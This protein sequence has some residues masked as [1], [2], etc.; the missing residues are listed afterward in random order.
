MKG[1]SKPYR[2]FKNIANEFIKN[3]VVFSLFAIILVTAFFI[4]QFHLL[5]NWDFITRIDNAN[6]LFYS[7]K[8]FD[9]PRAILE[10]FIIGI[11]SYVF[12]GY[13]AYA[14]I[15]LFSI[16][17]A[18]SIYEV[19]KAL[20]LNHFLLYLFVLSPFLIY[21]GI[22]N[23]SELPVI[24]FLL[25]TFAYSLKRKAIAG[26]FLS[27]AILSKYYAIFFIPILFVGIRKKEKN[28]KYIV[29][30]LA[31]MIISLIPYFL[32]EKI[33]FGN[34]ATSILLSYYS[35]LG[36][37]ININAILLGLIEIIFPLSL[38]IIYHKE[39]EKT[40]K[41]KRA[42]SIGIIAL[43][44]IALLTFIDTTKLASGTN[45]MRFAL[46]MSVFS[47]IFAFYVLPKKYQRTFAY[48]SFTLS[49]IIAIILIQELNQAMP[50][51][52]IQR[53]INAYALVFGNKSCIVESPIW[54]YLANKNIP[55][56]PP[57]LKGFDL[58][59][60][61]NLGIKPLAKYS[62]TYVYGNNTNCVSGRI[63]LGP[64]LIIIKYY[65][66]SQA[67]YSNIVNGTMQEINKSLFNPCNWAF[68]K[69]ILASACNQINDII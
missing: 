13:A 65:N 37:K 55:A 25:F 16:L 68:G 38:L 15:I 9:I 59:T 26:I 28:V 7:G 52:R 10:S 60:D 29:E 53:E 46:P 61:Q 12:G 33:F 36:Y 48:I 64:G 63:M 22:K 32:Y 57:L 11:L 5:N 6:F 34:W 54:V 50:I 35:T 18:I 66:N 56:I 69:S 3:E 8:Y 47:Y 21:W 30:S 43:I 39:L 67:Y 14:F 44:L 40:L 51:S 62:N 19:A 2:I 24:T 42:E 27:L 1:L 17:F 49:I 20:N 23:G 58:I 45:M 41:T 31:L 4:I